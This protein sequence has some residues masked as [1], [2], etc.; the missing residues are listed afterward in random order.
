MKRLFLTWQAQNKESRKWYP[1]G[2][3][4]FDGEVYRFFYIKGAEIAKEE[5]DFQPLVSFPDIRKVYESTELFPMFAN[6]VM[7]AS[8][9]EYQ[10][11]VEWLAL[12]ENQNDPL[13]FLAR[14]GGAKV[15]DKFEIFCYPESD[16]NGDYN[17]HFFPHGLRYVP[18][19]SIERIGKMERGEKV[20]LASAFQN[21][22][23]KKALQLQTRDNHIVGY[24]PSYLLNDMNDIVQKEAEIEVCVER[25]NDEK[26]PLQFRFLCRLIIPQKANYSPFSNQNYKP[27]V[28]TPEFVT[29]LNLVFA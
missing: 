1:V 20:Y 24:C 18:E 23:D 14:T 29:D 10:Q 8:R 12:A 5:A 3:L 22:F 19:D 11:T 16:E 15:T 21:P 2:E 28:N 4:N 13:A 27:I 7:P 25:V 9:P 17:L 26:S 6:R